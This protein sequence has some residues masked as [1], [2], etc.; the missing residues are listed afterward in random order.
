MSV[1]L[2]VLYSF[3]SCRST[4]HCLLWQA[5]PYLYMVLMPFCRSRS[6]Y[7]IRSI[8]SNA[9]RHPTSSPFPSGYLTSITMPIPSSSNSTRISLKSSSDSALELMIQSS[10]WL[11]SP[12][13]IPWHPP[14]QWHHKNGHSFTLPSMCRAKTRKPLVFP[15]RTLYLKALWRATIN[16]GYRADFGIMEWH[17]IS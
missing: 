7:L 13:R 9:F 2:V 12:G 1:I 14:L 11:S 4:W 5:I 3:Y 8:C 10:L 17:D 16:S 15:F 6:S